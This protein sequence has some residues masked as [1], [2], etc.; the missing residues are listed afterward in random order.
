MPGELL[1]VAR[2]DEE[3]YAYLQA[4]LGRAT[5]V[6]LDQR[7]RERRG[8]G[9]GHTP[10]RRRQDRRRRNHVDADLRLLGFATVGPRQ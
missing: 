1:I 10:E 4:K 7:I 2:G 3:L 5:A 8:G 6:I 9:G